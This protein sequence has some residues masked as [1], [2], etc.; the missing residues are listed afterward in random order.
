ML[1]FTST[2]TMKYVSMNFFLSNT[3]SVYFTWFITYHL[4]IGNA[5]TSKQAGHVDYF[6]L[7]ILRDDNKVTLKTPISNYYFIFFTLSSN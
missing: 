7:L 3:F 6:L 5:H 2:G 4:N 1:S